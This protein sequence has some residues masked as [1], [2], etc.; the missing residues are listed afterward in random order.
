MP[1]P[2]LTPLI[3]ATETELNAIDC[4]AATRSLVLTDSNIRSLLVRAINEA[5][6]K[7]AKSVAGSDK[8]R[9][10]NE[11]LQSL[12]A[13][14]ANVI[15]EWKKPDGSTEERPLPNANWIAAWE[16]VK[17]SCAVRTGSEPG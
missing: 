13:V 8:D 12:L 15:E 10:L 7:T 6:G 17:D 5:K 9:F 11:A 4:L 16:A 3:L 14:R 1:D 2:N